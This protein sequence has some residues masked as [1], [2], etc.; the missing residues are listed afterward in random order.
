[1]KPFDVQ[2]SKSNVF[3]WLN[4]KPEL[5]MMC[6]HVSFFCLLKYVNNLNVLLDFT[7]H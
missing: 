6:Y 2:S 5:D 4:L 1:M 7:L 3:D